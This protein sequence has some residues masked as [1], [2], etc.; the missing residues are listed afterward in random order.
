MK[1]L[2][3]PFIALICFY[4]S[5]LLV[6]YL[7]M[8]VFNSDRV[9][10]P[11]FLIIFILLMSVYYHNASAMLYAFIFGFLYDSFFTEVL[12]VHLFIFPFVT[13]LTSR[14]M[15]VLHS[16]LLVTS[17]VILLNLSILEFL[18]YEINLLIGK[19]DWA[20]AM[21]ADLRL[22]PTLVLNA[23]FLIIFSYPLKSLLMKLQKERLED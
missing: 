11:H 12:G 5:S 18:V 3:L 19:T 14:M 1:K 8:G 9:L 23:A 13:F 20:I 10:V 4:G 15:K 17:I 21:F 22:W 16:N 2:F 6:T 7:P